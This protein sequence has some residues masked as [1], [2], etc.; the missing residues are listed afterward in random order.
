MCWTGLLWSFTSERRKC[1]TEDVG[2]FVYMFSSSCSPLTELAKG[3]SAQLLTVQD[4]LLLE[5]VRQLV[6][7]LIMPHSIAGQ[8]CSGPECTQG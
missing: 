8:D 7:F 5:E 4:D 6:S 3:L 1:N 2:L